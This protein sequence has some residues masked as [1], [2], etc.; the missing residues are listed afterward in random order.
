M[1]CSCWY[2]AYISIVSV[3]KLIVPPLSVASS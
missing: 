3:A 1:R 2:V